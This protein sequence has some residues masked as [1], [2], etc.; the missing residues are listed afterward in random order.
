VVHLGHTSRISPLFVEFWK[1]VGLARYFRKRADTPRRQVLAW[2]LSPVV[3]GVSVVRPA[4]RR[5]NRS[6]H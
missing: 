4:L 2:V 1:G 5:L 6:R 3:V